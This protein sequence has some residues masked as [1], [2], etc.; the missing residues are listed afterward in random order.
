[1]A[2]VRPPLKYHLI[3]PIKMR[4]DASELDLNA[5]QAIADEKVLS[6]S[7][8]V[9]LVAWYQGRDGSFY[10]PDDE[11]RSQDKPSWIVFAEHCGA[12]MTVD[13]NDEQYVFVYVTLPQPRIESV[14]AGP[15][16]VP[17]A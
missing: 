14:D 10:P 2:A 8:Q 12:D 13:I 7:A 5:A 1:M 17:S 4:V 6:L 16:E 15:T 9:R 11:G 3:N